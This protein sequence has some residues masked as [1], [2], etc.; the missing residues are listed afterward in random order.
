MTSL[1]QEGK[2][3]LT[4]EKALLGLGTRIEWFDF[5]DC[6]CRYRRLNCFLFNGLLIA[7]VREGCADFPASVNRGLWNA[8]QTE[9]LTASCV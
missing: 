1:L 7:S 6:L 9:L 8:L 5:P 3:A 2:K 4:R